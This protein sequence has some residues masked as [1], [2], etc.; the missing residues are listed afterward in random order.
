MPARAVM[1]GLFPLDK[2]WHLD[3]SAYTR[4]LACQMV[5]L[6][7]LLPYAQCQMVFKSIGERWVSASSIWRQTHKHGERLQT[8]VEQQRQQVGVERIQLPDAKHDH[9]QRKGVSMDGG[10]VNIRGEGWR[11]LKVGTVFDVEI[12]LERN[13]QTQAL[14]EMA[15]GTQVHYTAV[16]GSKDD[17][18]PALW[19]LAVQH[20]LPTAR[21]RSVVAD[22][23]LWIWDVAEDICPDGQQ[24]VDW[25]HAV[26]H[27]SEAAY[28]LY[29]N[30][31]D[32][33]KRERWLKTYKDHLY[34]G[35][36]HKIIAV[37]NQ[38]G[39]PQLATYFERHQRRMQYLEFR[40]QGLPI[41]SGTVESGVKQFKQRLS[42]TGMRWHLDN[43]NRML[44]IRSAVL[45]NDFHHLW[46][47]A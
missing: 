22:G 45:G 6:S 8:Y 3:A 17:F 20:A 41:G 11:E 21:N 32:A 31:N 34:M 25:F 47:V 39:F 10:M 43:A 9:D 33:V 2:Q 14:D 36:I 12:R 4:A 38:R 46:N 24:V 13:P 28:A 16:L 27:L 26:E 5:W 29:P 42:G 44:V 30:T 40:E 23:A 35:R 1:Q 7:G 15:H 19:A 18:R 37:L